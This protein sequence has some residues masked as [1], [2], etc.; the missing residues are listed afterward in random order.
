MKPND[1]LE[2]IRNELLRT[3]SEVTRKGLDP[4]GFL[5]VE[6]KG[7]AVEISKKRDNKW[8]LE[9][10]ELDAEEG[11]DP[12]KESTVDTI[13]AAVREATQWLEQGSL[14]NPDQKQSHLAGK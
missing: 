6:N 11:A 8:W 3:F 13:E 12:A 1:E 5:F 9:F 4:W 14:H 2:I 7:R 10:W